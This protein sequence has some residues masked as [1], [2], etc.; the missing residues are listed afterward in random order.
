VKGTLRGE[1]AALQ[2]AGYA[3]DPGYAE[4]L[5]AVFDGRTMQAAIK[6]A[7]AAGCECCH[8]AT[9]VK[10]TDPAKAPLANTK[11][12]FKTANKEVIATTSKNGEIG[13]KP[14]PTTVEFIVEVWNELLKSWAPIEQKLQVSTAAKAHTLVSPKLTFKADTSR[15]QPI[16][17]A[18]GGRAAGMSA[19]SKG[20]KEYIIRRGDTLGA[21]A[22]K[23]D[24]SYRALASLNHIQPPYK[25]ISGG[26]LLVPTKVEADS[27]YSTTPAAA[28]SANGSETHILSGHA[29][30]GNPT[31]DVAVSQRAPW[32]SIA[33][34]ERAL[35]IRR[36]GGV[37][38]DK[39]IKEYASA[40]SMGKTNDSGYAYC[41]AFV[42]WCL[43]RSGYKG[44]GSAMAASFKSW[45]RSTKGGKPAYVAVA[46]IKFPTGGHHVTFIVGQKGRGRVSTLG[47]NQGEDHAVSKSSVPISWI[48]AMRYP[49]DYPDRNEDYDLGHD[50]EISSGMSYEST[51]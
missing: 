39:H 5:E 33:E 43:V 24:C 37:L 8:G 46:V 28:S 22:A 44:D 34:N 7:E 27:K 3:T 35:G 38:S 6:E 13:L 9:I 29:L 51:H 41:A 12:K 2:K 47:G 18:S 30:A 31:S 14:T 17:S 40:T 19:I 23:N 16:S 10:F 20:T 45:G 1:A 25:I 42:N 11:V 48:V 32:I 21:I 50:A 26:V 15:H 4:K 36:R 49:A